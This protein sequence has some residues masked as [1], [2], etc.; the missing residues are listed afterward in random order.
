MTPARTL[1]KRA[2]MPTTGRPCYRSAHRSSRPP[3]CAAEGGSVGKPTLDAS[4][5]RQTPAPRPGTVE[6]TTVNPQPPEDTMPA[7]T[8]PR[9]IRPA[10][11]PAYYLGR[12]ASVWINATT[13]HPGAR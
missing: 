11:A 9:R 5:R 8:Q 13:S 4:A 12:P 2:R 6:L 1:D 10:A 7:T 3:Q